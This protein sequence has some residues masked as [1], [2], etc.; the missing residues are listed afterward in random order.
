M[1]EELELFPNK[2][3]VVIQRNM[4]EWQLRKNPRPVTSLQPT[5]TGEDVRD[6]IASDGRITASE[7]AEDV[8]VLFGEGR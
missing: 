7:D 1:T 4:A 2:I 8:I 3:P 6:R 5:H